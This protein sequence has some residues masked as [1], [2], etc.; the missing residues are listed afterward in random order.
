MLTTSTLPNLGGYPHSRGGAPVGNQNARTHGR[1]A[2]SSVIN[3]GAGNGGG[4]PPPP[5]NL[6]P[7][8]DALRAYIQRLVLAGQNLTDL[9]DIACPHPG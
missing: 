6:A 2:R 1:Y 5:P 9:N 7:E 3:P 8:I 4:P